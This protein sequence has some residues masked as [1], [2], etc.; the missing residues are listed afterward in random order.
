MVRLHKGRPYEYFL[1]RDLCGEDQQFFGSIPGKYGRWQD[2]GGSGTLKSYLAA[3]HVVSN[4]CE[5][6]AMD[7]HLSWHWDVPSTPVGDVTIDYSVEWDFLARTVAA[8]LGLTW[9]GGSADAAKLFGPGPIPSIQVPMSHT[10][11]WDTST[12]SDSSVWNWGTGSIATHLAIGY[13]PY[14]WPP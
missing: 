1:W 7:P 2:Y 3:S 12:T 14:P 4:E 5:R 8:T 9:S 10:M 11:L 13:T 6:R